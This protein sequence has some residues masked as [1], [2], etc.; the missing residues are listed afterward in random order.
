[1]QYFYFRHARKAISESTNSKQAAVYRK[2]NKQRLV[3]T[4]HH[5]ASKTNRHETMHI[6]ATL[7]PG[8]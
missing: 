6:Y 7:K 3:T 8:K 4:A 5:T 2:Q 1:M